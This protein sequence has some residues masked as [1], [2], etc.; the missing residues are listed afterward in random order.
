MT[1][2]AF[3]IET[4]WE[5]ASASDFIKRERRTRVWSRT[6]DGQPAVLKLYRQ[7]GWW[8]VCRGALI[9]HR[10]ER[11]LKALSRLDDAGV[12]CTRPLGWW[13]GHAKQHGFW[14][15]LATSQV[16]GAK[17]LEALLVSG[18]FAHEGWSLDAAFELV[19]QMHDSGVA[20]GALYARNILAGPN[21]NEYWICDMAKSLRYPTS[22]VGSR[23]ARYEIL[24]LCQSLMELGFSAE[25]LPFE[26]YGLDH[27]SLEDLRQAVARYRQSK[28]RNRR[29]NLVMRAKVLRDS[30]AAGQPK[31]ALQA[32]G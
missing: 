19:R 29:R 26:A 8:S 22:I 9:Q 7:R 16:A 15:L 25:Q 2:S 27:A 11:E 6:L 32:I 3:A 17:D 10:S 30:L 23:T 5:A 18:E 13:R 28:I 21:Q 12:R 1:T 20:H 31:E 24:D 14:E 4:L